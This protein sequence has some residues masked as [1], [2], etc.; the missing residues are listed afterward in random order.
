MISKIPPACLAA[1]HKKQEDADSS[2]MKK[3]G[4]KYVNN[5]MNTEKVSLVVLVS[6]F[7][8]ITDF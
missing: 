6:A 3:K 8:L 7:C 2:R 4:M 5:E 1:L